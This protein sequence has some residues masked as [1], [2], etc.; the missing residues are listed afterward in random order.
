MNVRSLRPFAAAIAVLCGLVLGATHCFAQLESHTIPQSNPA[1]I[2]AADLSVFENSPTPPHRL[3]YQRPSRLSG[4]RLSGNRLFVI[5]A[6]PAPSGW[7]RDAESATNATARI[8]PANDVRT[9]PH[10]G[11]RTQ[12]A[13]PEIARPQFARS[14]FTRSQ[15]TPVQTSQ[16]QSQSQSPFQ[17]QATSPDSVARPQTAGAGRYLVAFADPA[18]MPTIPTTL[19]SAELPPP[20]GSSNRFELDPPQIDAGEGSGSKPSTVIEMTD[21]DNI[22]VGLENL[23]TEMEEESR[24]RVDASGDQNDDVPADAD[25]DQDKDD[26]DDQ[27]DQEDQGDGEDEDVR[28]R[29][30]QF[31]AWPKKSMAQVNIDVR[32][33]GQTV[34]ADESG[35]LSTSSQRYYNGDAKTHKVF[36]WTAPNIRHQPLYFE[37]ASLERYGQTKG[38]VKQPFVSAFEF[39]RDA[40]L[41]P[42]NASIDCPYACDTPLGFSRP[43]SPRN[44]SCDCQ[45]CVECSGQH[46]R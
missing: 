6:P 27:E 25:D 1:E 11:T 3:A 29:S 10:F 46:Q 28:Q 18:A 35:V 24:D 16:A 44:G 12:F 43:G 32:D 21:E 7:P 19:Q 2:P 9:A 23:E 34:P 13:R 42:L 14:K 8:I 20:A 5:E 26:L 36:A 15:A 41:L 38:I 31:G 17:P 22:D 4:N 45:K 39:A 37:D 30:R 33:F 40:A